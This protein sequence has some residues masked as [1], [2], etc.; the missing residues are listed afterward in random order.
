M[1][2]NQSKSTNPA[3]SFSNS[4]PQITQ[5]P[6]TRQLESTPIVQSLLELFQVANPKGL[7]LL[8]LAFPM[9]TPIWALAQAIPSLLSSA[10]WPNPGVTPVALCGRGWPP[11]LGP[12]SK[13]NVSLPNL[14]LVSFCGCSNF[15][16]P[17]PTC[18][19]L[20]HCRFQGEEQRGELERREA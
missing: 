11:T 7:T 1:E 18:T 10:T 15:N 3:T 17:Y 12:L 20:R 5:G 14:L 4:L 9:E 8:C 6:G 13:I 2:T 16:V 19:F